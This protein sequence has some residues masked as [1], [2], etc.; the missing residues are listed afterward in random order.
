MKLRAHYL[1][2]LLAIGCASAKAPPRP[3]DLPHSR[4]FVATFDEVW[5]ATVQVLDL[6]SI[7]EASRESGL[8]RT[9]VSNFANNSGLYDHPDTDDRLD[10]VRYYLTIKLSK[11]LVSQ[12]GKSAVRVQVT[13]VYEKYGNLLTDWERIAS[14]ENEERIILYRIGQRLRIASTIKRRRAIDAQ[15]KSAAP[16]T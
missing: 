13:K 15:K 6:Y 4:I 11:G 7:V 3:V 9:E 12:T 16:A 2:L 8:L 5:N 14:D 10:Q 1:S